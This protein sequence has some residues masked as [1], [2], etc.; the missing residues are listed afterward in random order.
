LNIHRQKKVN[1]IAKLKDEISKHLNA[2]NEV[3]AKI[4]CE[5]LINDEG[6]IPCF[7]ITH[8][9]CDQIKGRLDYLE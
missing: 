3:N 2:D 7:D 5:T 4:W 6:M 8:T 9:M 1:S